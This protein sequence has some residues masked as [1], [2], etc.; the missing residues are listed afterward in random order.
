MRPR[1]KDMWALTLICLVAVPLE[2]LIFA[3]SRSQ[4][5]GRVINLSV[6]TFLS[7]ILAGYALHQL[8]QPARKAMAVALS[9]IVLLSFWALG[10]FG[11]YHSPWISQPS[12][13]ITQEDVRGIE[14]FLEN[15]DVDVPFSA[16]GYPQGVPYVALGHSAATT[17]ED[18]TKPV[19][20]MLRDLEQV[21]PAGFGYNRSTTLG[22]S[23]DGDRYL[24]IARRFQIATEDPRL[25]SSG[26]TTIPLFWPGFQP[27]D[28]ENLNR[29]PSVSKLYS[30]G[31]FD[32]YYVRAAP[33]RD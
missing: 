2:L 25:R 11:I 6:A 23:L 22:N 9:S 33:R 26:L 28:F 24:L 16:M 5:I 13:Q 1:S 20:Q 3:G 15:K 21:L 32:I 7:P 8:L 29:D 30:N 19:L 4:T 31:E 18:L 27:A 14:W 12:W 10:A 17:R